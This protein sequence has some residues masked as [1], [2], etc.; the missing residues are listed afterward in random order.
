MGKDRDKSVRNARSGASSA[1]AA[2]M[3]AAMGASSGLTFAA[4]DTSG[5]ASAE[6]E[7]DTDIGACFAPEKSQMPK[8]ELA[9]D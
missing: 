8:R 6:A 1:N 4:F 5:S 9:P 7:I 3:V 2:A